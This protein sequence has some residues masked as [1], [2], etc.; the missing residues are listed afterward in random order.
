M[1]GVLLAGGSEFVIFGIRSS[2]PDWSTVQGVRPRGNTLRLPSTA[3][4]LS[5]FGKKL[6][7]VRRDFFCVVRETFAMVGWSKGRRGQ[8]SGRSAPR[9]ELGWKAQATVAPPFSRA[10]ASAGPAVLGRGNERLR[11]SAAAG[12]TYL[13]CRGSGSVLTVGRAAS[14]GRPLRPIALPLDVARIFVIPCVLHRLQQR[15]PRVARHLEVAIAL[16][17]TFKVALTWR[18]NAGAVHR[19]DEHAIFAIPHRFNGDAFLAVE[20]V[21]HAFD[22]S[23]AASS[24]GVMRHTPP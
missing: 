14:F 7:L 19:V 6:Q 3:K 20:A 15:P 8:R 11:Q 2:D 13:A 24:S 18:K 5:L 21:A 4:S 12:Q 10:G 22:S 23:S 16:F 9:A 1:V 17:D